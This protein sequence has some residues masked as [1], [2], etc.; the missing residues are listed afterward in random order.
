[1]RVELIGG[2]FLVVEWIKS[3]NVYRYFACHEY[4]NIYRSHIDMHGLV[5]TV[6]RVISTLEGEVAGI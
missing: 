2:I 4:I 1:M 3:S 6:S 5:A